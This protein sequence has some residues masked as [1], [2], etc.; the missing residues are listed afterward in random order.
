VNPAPR[1]KLHERIKA[2][3]AADA[4]RRFEYRQRNLARGVWFRLRRLLSRAATAW[5]IEEEDARRLLDEGIR[6]QGV[7]LEIE[8]PIQI[9]VVP[10][11]RIQTLATRQ[12]L[13]VRLSAELLTTRHLALVLW[14][15]EKADD[16]AG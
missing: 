12:P 6:P 13:T 3:R 16:V 9:L 11:Q 2:A 4:I 15:Q 8:P 1:A 14:P 5:Q 10:E 7:G